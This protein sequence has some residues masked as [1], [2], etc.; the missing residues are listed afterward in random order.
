[1]ALER[2]RGK[3]KVESAEY[4]MVVKRV[5]VPESFPTKYDPDIH[6][7]KVYR[8]A[9]I[10]LRGADLA[11]AMDVCESTIVDW[12]KIHPE[13]AEAMARGLDVADSEVAI[14]LFQKATGYSHPAEEIRVVDGEVVRIPVERRY[15]PDTTAAIFWLK[16]RQRGVW[17][18][19]WNI[20]HSGKDGQELKQVHQV[21]AT[22]DLRK[23]STQE[24]EVVAALGIKVGNATKE[25]TNNGP[26][27]KEQEI[28]DI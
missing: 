26:V 21:I 12:K 1:M 22:M 15:P 11:L 23:L 16:N 7:K 9:M 8:M 28:L 10:G 27:E 25:L 4:P 19:V 5:R 13:F 14:A 3:T 18:D 2:N 24:L 20:E 17:R 6:P